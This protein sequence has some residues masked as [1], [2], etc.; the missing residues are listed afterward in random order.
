MTPNRRTTLKLHLVNC[1]DL[2]LSDPI[3]EFPT[4]HEISKV[5]K[6]R[7]TKNFIAEGKGVPTVPRERS[8]SPVSSRGGPSRQAPCSQCSDTEKKDPSLTAREV[9]PAVNTNNVCVPAEREV[10]PADKSNMGVGPSAREVGPGADSEEIQGPAEREVGPAAIPCC[11]LSGSD[12][13]TR[14]GSHPKTKPGKYGII[15]LFDGVSSV[16][17][18]L[19]KKLGCPPTAIL[20]A[21]NDE[22]VRR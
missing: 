20:L 1:E 9:G 6:G 3:S 19:T 17:R 22:A 5:G 10:G 2:P 7:A 14:H 21:E 16:V 15:S 11:M 4:S 12:E 8:R 18:L 13:V